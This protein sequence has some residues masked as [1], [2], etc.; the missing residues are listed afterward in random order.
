MKYINRPPLFKIKENDICAEVGVWKGDFSH[1][2][3]GQNPKEL[4]LIDPWL[5]QKEWGFYGKH[6]NLQRIEQEE[7]DSIYINVCNKFK[8]NNK[9]KIHRKFSTET[10]F[11]LHYFD[12][13]YIDGDHSYSAVSKDLAHYYPLVKKGGYL[14]GDDYGL[15]GDEGPSRAVDEFVN[16]NN[17]KVEVIKDTFNEKIRWTPQFIIKV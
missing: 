15:L 11:S 1:C 16:K 9:V 3:L 12:W 7:M 6:N 5:Y 14:C 4:H 17:L 10:E 2:I 13:V 8:N